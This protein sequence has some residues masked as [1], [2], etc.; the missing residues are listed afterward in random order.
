MARMPSPDAPRTVPVARTRVSPVPRLNASMPLSAPLTSTASI[1]ISCAVASVGAFSWFS[2]RI[3]SPPWAV[4]LPPVLIRI[5]SSPLFMATTPDPDEATSALSIV[6]PEAASPFSMEI[7]REFSSAK[8]LT[9]PV[10]RTEVPDTPSFTMPIP[11]ALPATSLATTSMPLRDDKIR[12]RCTM[13]MP[14]P[15]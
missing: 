15:S 3:P 5:A 2:A 9:V 11:F 13:S 14:L 10:V 4:T 1:L 7:P 12:E 6:M 8:A